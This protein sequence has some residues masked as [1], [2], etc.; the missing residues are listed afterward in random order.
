MR[1]QCFITR[2]T[3]N[4]VPLA[5]QDSERSYICVRSIVLPLSVGFRYN[6]ATI[7]IYLYKARKVKGHIFL[8]K[9][10]D[11]SSFCVFTTEYWVV[12][13]KKYF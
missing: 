1:T 6:V 5:R 12:S 8:C 10:T 9:N 4:E 2:P 7:Q 3:F 11:L 13:I